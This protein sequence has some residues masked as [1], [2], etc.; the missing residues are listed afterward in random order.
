MTCLYKSDGQKAQYFIEGNTNNA[1]PG[2]DRIHLLVLKENG[3]VI[4]GADPGNANGFAYLEGGNNAFIYPKDP[5]AKKLD[6]QKFADKGGGV[7]GSFSA[8]EMKNGGG[9]VRTLTDR[10]IDIQIGAAR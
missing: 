10:V 7:T 2:S 1:G 3:K 5:A 9:V 6:A 8:S 4:W